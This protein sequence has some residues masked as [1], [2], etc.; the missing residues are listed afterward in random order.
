MKKIKTIITSILAAAML[1]FGFG[2][3]TVAAF[4]DEGAENAVI[5]AESIS[6]EEVVEETESVEN[7]AVIETEDSATESVEKETEVTFEDILNLAGKLAEKEGFKDE[8][9]KTLYYLKTAASEKKVDAMI[10]LLGAVFAF[11]L[12]YGVIKLRSWY[13]KIKTDTTSK[14][15][16]DIK[17][18]SGQQTKAINGLIDE[19][20]T[21]AD[22][23]K[24]DI[25]RE[26]AL[27]NGIEKQNVALRCLIRGT[28]I[29]QDLKDEAFRALNESDDSCDKARE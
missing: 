18:A 5:S 12:L 6:V 19:G 9:D 3:S 27:A 23:V 22:E 20:T 11:L 4:A 7:S 14:D 8:W 28:Q 16:A 26:K 25:E 21:L 2:L 24:E 15:I 17:D 13:K 1:S 10:I 29:K